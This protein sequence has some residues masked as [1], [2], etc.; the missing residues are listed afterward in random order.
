MASDA[1][2]TVRLPEALL[3]ELDSLVGPKETRADVVRSLLISGMDMRRETE[4]LRNSVRADV[5]EALSEQQADL[6]ERLQYL[7]A[8]ANAALWLLVLMQWQDSDGTME[9]WKNT[10]FAQGTLVDPYIKL[11][12][13][14][15]RTDD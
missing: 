1:R 8:R 6:A 12:E 2:M 5:V 9:W 15:E 7:E 4:R 10:A 3:E 11:E 14:I 13:P